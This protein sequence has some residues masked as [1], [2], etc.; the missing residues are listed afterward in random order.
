MGGCCCHS[1]DE[2]VCGDPAEETTSVAVGFVDSID[3]LRGFLAG[4]DV[5]D[6]GTGV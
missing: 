4:L 2:T 6:D 1:G 3:I 5:I